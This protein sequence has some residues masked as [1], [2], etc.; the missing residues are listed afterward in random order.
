[1]ATGYP[2][3]SAYTGAFG[4]LPPLINDRV[5]SLDGQPI[6]T[7]TSNSPAGVFG[8]ATSISSQRSKPSESSGQSEWTQQPPIAPLSMRRKITPPPLR[9]GGSYR[10]SESQERHLQHGVH[11]KPAP[12]HCGNDFGSGTRSTTSDRH[13]STPH[14]HSH[15]YFHKERMVGGVHEYGEGATRSLPWGS[16]KQPSGRKEEQTRVQLGPT[17]AMTSQGR[18]SENASNQESSFD[19]HQADIVFQK[20]R[21]DMTYKIMQSLNSLP[22][23]SRGEDSSRRSANQSINAMKVGYGETDR[24]DDVQHLEVLERRRRLGLASSGGNTA[25]STVLS[26]RQV[27]VSSVADIGLRTPQTHSPSLDH[28]D[29][30]PEAGRVD[31]IEKGNLNIPAQGLTIPK[32]PREITGVQTTRI[33]NEETASTSSTATSRSKAVC[34]ACGVPGS[35]VTPL[36]PCSRCRKGYHDRCGNPKPQNSAKLDDFICGRCLRK[37]SRE[38]PSIPTPKPSAVPTWAQNARARPVSLLNPVIPGAMNPCTTESLSSI[39]RVNAVNAAEITSAQSEPRSTIFSLLN[40]EV[41]PKEAST[42]STPKDKTLTD[43]S[44]KSNKHMAKRHAITFDPRKRRAQQLEGKPCSTLLGT[45][46]ADAVSNHNRPGILAQTP[47]ASTGQPAGGL[48]RRQQASLVRHDPS[49]PAP[50]EPEDGHAA[51]LDAAHNY[52]EKFRTQC[53]DDSRFN[54][55]LD[56]LK[57]FEDPAVNFP[58]TVQK[59]A[60]LF[61]DRPVLI[62][63]LNNLL[64]QG[65]LIECDAQEVTDLIGPEVSDGSIPDSSG[66]KA[67]MLST[68]ASLKKI[69]TDIGSVAAEKKLCEGCHKV[70][71]GRTSRCVRCSLGLVRHKSKEKASAEVMTD[72][73]VVSPVAPVAPVAPDSATPASD[74]ACPEGDS[75]MQNDHRTPSP[76]ALQQRLMPNT[77]KRTV[78]EQVLFVPRKKTKLAPLAINRAKESLRRLSLSH[79]AES[80]SEA[81]A[82]ALDTGLE[83]RRSLEQLTR[84]AI[85]EEKGAREKRTTANTTATAYAP[86][87]E[88]VDRSHGSRE[89]LLDSDPGRSREPA[90]SFP[91]VGAGVCLDDGL[92]AEAPDNLHMTEARSAGGDDTRPLSQV[93]HRTQVAHGTIHGTEVVRDHLRRESLETTEMQENTRNEQ[94]PNDVCATV[95]ACKTSPTPDRHDSMSA[96]PDLEESRS[97][98]PMSTCGRLDPLKFH[99]S[100]RD[101]EYRCHGGTSSTQR[102]D[103]SHTASQDQQT[104]L[105]SSYDRNSTTPP[106]DLVGSSSETLIGVRPYQITANDPE[107][108]DDTRD[109]ATLTQTQ[110]TRRTTVSRQLATTMSDIEDGDD[111]PLNSIR[112][113]DPVPEISSAEVF[114]MLGRHSVLSS[115]SQPSSTITRADSRQSEVQNSSPAT[116]IDQAVWTEAEE[117]ASVARLKA[118]GAIFESESDSDPTDRTHD[119]VALPFQRPIDPPWKLRQRSSNLFDILNG[120]EDYSTTQVSL[121]PPSEARPSRKQLVGNLLKYQ[122]REQRRKFGNPHQEVNRLLEGMQVTADVQCE[123]RLDTPDSFTVGRFERTTVIMSVEEFMGV[124]EEPVVALDKDK[125]ALVFIEGK[126]HRGGRTLRSPRRIKDAE[127]FPFAYK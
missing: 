106:G 81:E 90:L 120:A 99:E 9:R 38:V 32:T 20:K 34:K 103:M 65:Y 85:L 75:Q 92:G 69:A 43:S 4:F 67:T 52:L 23:S 31:T 12:I 11:Y 62:R 26:S 15:D 18:D 82:E 61:S 37:R 86:L 68:H 80:I 42:R 36:V 24:G 16:S 1:M 88:F 41:W 48:F 27:N 126:N 71:F 2:A 87:K 63:E 22:E 84:L 94:V 101:R 118:Q 89:A 53:N 5:S 109:D 13:G 55:F 117:N 39:D 6:A 10:S 74:L 47:L 100:L 44:S 35:Q 57:D 72:M 79:N 54:N 102:G 40:N 45:E 77:L 111:V 127:K 7:Q 123:T 25:L 73:S 78:S 113:N 104:D 114:S 21:K 110:P 8:G 124:P 29:T 33:S 49:G 122:C 17:P 107:D 97:D 58:E 93:K 115:S 91:H 30:G 3:S 83:G 66:H 112:D 19:A 121:S 14:H 50:F 105:A 98:D 60:Q 119:L 116:E 95:R 125:D 59:L 108:E 70:I 46:S 28:R 76:P 96:D 56:I 64:P 51:T